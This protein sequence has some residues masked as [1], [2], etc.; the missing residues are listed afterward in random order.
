MILEKIVQDMKP[1]LEAAKQQ[2]PPAEMK[3]LAAKASPPKDFRGAFENRSKVNVIAE[4]K[5]ASPSKGMIRTDFPYLKLAAELEHAG[6]AALSV[7]TERNYFHGSLE[8]LR[9]VSAAVSIPVLRKD[10]ISDPYQIYE[11]RANGADAILLIAAMLDKQKIADFA[12]TASDLGMTVLGEAH[13]R[14]ELEL[15]LDCPDITLLGVNARD[16]RTFHTDLNRTY[17]LI[18]DIPDDRNAIAESAIRTPQDIALLRSAGAAG[19][20][21]G[22]TLMRADHPGEKLRE[23][24]G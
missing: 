7:L 4:L 9:E 21:I 6:A 18:R 12:K 14:Q 22:E 24:I 23:L 8:Y 20:L 16:L 5:K 2:F 19:F 15:L 17:E 11:A 3:R 1:A 13:T 10:F